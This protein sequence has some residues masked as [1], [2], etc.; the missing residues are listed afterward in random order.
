MIVHWSMVADG[1]GMSRLS[2]VG[3]GGIEDDATIE[4]IDR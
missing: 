3:Y 4:G 2:E 1:T